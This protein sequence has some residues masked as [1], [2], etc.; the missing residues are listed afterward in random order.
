VVKKY[1]LEQ[2]LGVEKIDFTMR[3]PTSVSSRSWRS[4]SIDFIDSPAGAGAAAGAGNR[5]QYVIWLGWANRWLAWDVA[6][7]EAA[8]VTPAAQQRW[9]QTARRR[10]IEMMKSAGDT[11]T[12]IRF[13]STL[14]V[15]EDRKLIESQ[16]SAGAFSSGTSSTPTDD[17][18]LYRITLLSSEAWLR[19]TAD[20]ALA[21]WDEPR[22]DPNTPERAGHDGDRPLI[23]LGEIAGT[24]KLPQ[25]PPPDCGMH[26]YLIPQQTSADRWS[27]EK[28]VQ[29]LDVTFSHYNPQI[30]S[31]DLPFR[32]RGVTP[33]HYWAKA[34]FDV[35]P[36][37]HDD[38]DTVCRGDTGDYESIQ[39]TL[40]EVKAGE[41]ANLGDVPCMTK[42]TR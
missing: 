39:Q 38:R 25:D 18:K 10:A 6:T 34:V 32:I 12:A 13:L 29:R 20:H 15:P 26:I 40:F 24:L 9:Q 21:A 7:G 14:R 33:G 28:P 1:A 5:G 19:T 30:V 11:D 23:H 41:V 42:I 17:R 3:V 16:L 2:I 36:P 37:L 35:A 31:K 4:Q 22:A 8:A 27:D